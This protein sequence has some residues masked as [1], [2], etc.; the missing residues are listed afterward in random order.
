MDH[1]RNYI[2]TAITYDSSWE[3]TDSSHIC[4]NDLDYLPSCVQ[5]C[6]YV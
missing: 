1:E 2:S 4:L 6:G 5:M 3:N